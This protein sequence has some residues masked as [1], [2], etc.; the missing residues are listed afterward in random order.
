MYRPGRRECAV[1]AGGPS[2]NRV[3]DALGIEFVEPAD[4]LGVAGPRFEKALLRQ[5]GMH[6]AQARCQ[7]AR[8]EFSGY[9]I[10]RRVNF[11]PPQGSAVFGR[12]LELRFD[13]IPMQQFLIV[14]GL[15]NVPQGVPYGR[16]GPAKQASGVG[17]PVHFMG[18]L[19][20]LRQRKA[21]AR[22]HKK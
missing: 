5:I 18:G 12:F 21:L 9:R 6:G 20:V 4:G 15:G 22:S 3:A 1:I 10:I 11:V 14:V 13:P 2:A 7:Q 17:V 19:R 16:R 8:V